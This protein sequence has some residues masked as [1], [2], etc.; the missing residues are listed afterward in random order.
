MPRPPVPIT[1]MVIRSLAAAAAVLAQ[2][3]SR[4][5]VRETGYGRRAG[6]EHARDRSPSADP[7]SVSRNRDVVITWCSS[8]HVPRRD[9][10]GQTTC[11]ARSFAR[12]HPVFDP[13][14]EA[15][16]TWHRHNPAGDRIEISPRLAHVILPDWK[17][18]SPHHGA[19]PMKSQSNRGSSRRVFLAGA[20]GVA[21]LGAAPWIAR[22]GGHVNDRIGIGLIGVGGRGTDHLNFTDPAGELA[23]RPGHGGLRRL[24]QGKPYRGGKAGGRSSAM[25]RSS[26]PGSAICWSS[27]TSMQ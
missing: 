26:S 8:A 5:D 7:G 25:S 15:L 24:A 21:S 17:L 6:E 20:S 10:V 12:A 16:A 1:P 14:D 9:P 2:G 13:S 22:A 4:G 19:R 11:P 18:R 27:G 23:K 3:L